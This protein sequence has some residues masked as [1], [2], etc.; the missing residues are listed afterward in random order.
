MNN[1]KKIK[2]GFT[3]FWGGFNPTTDPIFSLLL[4]KHYDVIYDN[5]NPDVLFF[6]V[7]GDTHKQYNCKK[8]LFTPENFYSHRY[9]PLDFTLGEDNLYKYADYSIT[10]FDTGNEKNFRLPCYI[11]RYGHNI[12]DTIND[13]TIPK[14]SKKILYLQR[15]CVQFR[16]E[17]VLKLQKHIEVDCLGNCI[18][19]KNIDVID[20]IE[21]MKDYKF[22]MSFENSSYPGYNTEKLVDG[23]ISKTIPIYWGDT[24]VNSD[25]N[26]KSF[27]SY[28]DYND[29]DILIEKILELDNNE[30]KYNQM[31]LEQPIINYGL[32]DENKLIN[33]LN[34]ILL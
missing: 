8:I 24:N 12:K 32:F 16:D 30:S 2:I 4:N 13:R 23:F 28:H 7:D 26:P 21:F 14:K 11:R 5:I 9:R 22:V 25:Y 15:N 6:S 17:F 29:Q 20:K 34:K 31:L 1:N 19:N 3:D 10:G 27:L 18:R 33:F